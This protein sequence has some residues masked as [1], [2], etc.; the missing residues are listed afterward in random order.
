MIAKLMKY[1]IKN[2]MRIL[3]YIYVVSIGL[4]IIT[5]ILNIWSDIQVLFLIKE[6]FAGLT[7]S[8]VGSVIINAFAHVLKVLVCSFYKD[9]S[10]L[11]HTLPV[12]K[13]ELLLSKYL[14]GLVVVLCSVAIAFVSLAI[15]LY[16]P[17]FMDMLGVLLEMVVAGFNMSVSTFITI[18]VLLVFVQLCAMMSMV[19]VAVVKGNMYNS[20]R[21]IKGLLW[22]V[23]CYMATMCA[24]LLVIL[25]VFAIQGNVS[26][27][28]SETLSQ[29]AFMSIIVVCL[30]VYMLA[31][32]VFYIIANRLF[33]KGVNVD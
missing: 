10:Y 8:A 29:Q 13:S 18:F 31:S 11:T 9:E 1:D 22:F 25:A 4:S 7:Y 17:E 26:M 15:V 5:R 23:V 2:M 32:V 30:V 12:K 16:S 3:V 33:N 24:M 27:F 21:A 28:L 6:I 20:K 14:S 19:F